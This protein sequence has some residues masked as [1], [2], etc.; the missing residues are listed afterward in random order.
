MKGAFFL[1]VSCMGILVAC[2]SNRLYEQ[3]NDFDDRHWAVEEKPFFEFEIKNVEGTYNLYVNVRN[4]VSYPNA[5]LYFTYYLSDSTGTVIHQDLVTEFLFDKKTGKPFGSTVLGDIY[6]HQFPILKNYVFEKPGKYQVHYE[7]F[8]RY[9]T[10]RGILS[11]GLR[12]EKNL[13][14]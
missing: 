3:N 13:P 14:G 11:V 9:D 10:L 5:N 7:Q 4:T 2:D 12:V 8:M 6:D 1:L